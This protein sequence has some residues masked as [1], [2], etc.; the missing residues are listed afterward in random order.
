[1]EN[2]MLQEIIT[3]R[4]HQALVTRV[5][6][7]KEHMNLGSICARRQ[8]HHRLSKNLLLLQEEEEVLVIMISG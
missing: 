3:P 2:N 7:C 5:S 6:R 8:D 1:M 4:R